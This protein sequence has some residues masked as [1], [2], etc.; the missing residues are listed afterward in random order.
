MSSL[1]KLN[2]VINQIS[3]RLFD[4]PEKAGFWKDDVFTPLPKSILNTKI[5][6]SKTPM[7]IAIIWSRDK[8]I[9]FADFKG[10]TLEDFMKSIYNETQRSIGPKNSNPTEIYNLI[11]NFSRPK[12]RKEMI[13]N[14][15]KGTLKVAELLG[16]HYF[17][18]GGIRKEK[19][20][21]KTIYV[22]GIGS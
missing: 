13:E 21:G 20:D 4:K 17:F 16:D 15:E 8:P 5:T 7:K 11:G 6:T 10:T 9:Y 1:K 3:W 19:H 2:T 14:Y 18:D 12:T 22:F